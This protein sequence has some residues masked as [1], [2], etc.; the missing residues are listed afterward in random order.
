M[1]FPG[2]WDVLFVRTI[3]VFSGANDRL[4]WPGLNILMQSE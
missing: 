4:V 2:K 3:L 1:D